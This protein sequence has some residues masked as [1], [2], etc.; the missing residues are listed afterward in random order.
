VQEIIQ[1]D[2]IIITQGAGNVG[3]LAIE[4]H[5]HKLL[6]REMNEVNE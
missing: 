4:L 6:Y 3:S 1:A 5:K 2:D